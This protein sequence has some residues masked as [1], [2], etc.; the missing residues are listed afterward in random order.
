MSF[1]F[2]GGGQCGRMIRSNVGTLMSGE[3]RQGGEGG[4]KKGNIQV[5]CRGGTDRAPCPV[6]GTFDRG[7]DWSEIEVYRGDL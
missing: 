5:Q 1:G 2:I 6:R 7:S 4:I 3:G